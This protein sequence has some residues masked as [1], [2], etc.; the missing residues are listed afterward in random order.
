MFDVFW[1]KDYLKDRGGPSLGR[2]VN[3]GI[4]DSLPGGVHSIQNTKKGLAN[5]RFPRI[6]LSL[7]RTEGYAKRSQS[8]R[9][10]PVVPFFI[11]YCAPEKQGVAVTIAARFRLTVK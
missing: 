3:S 8:N 2:W 6:S 7:P 4:E 10:L 5:N 11:Q 1:K 9:F